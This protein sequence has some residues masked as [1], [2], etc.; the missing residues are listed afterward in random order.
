LKD[1]AL[2]CCQ[3]FLKAMPPFSKKKLFFTEQ[4]KPALARLSPVHLCMFFLF[5]SQFQK[6]I[7]HAGFLFG[8][9]Q[10]ISRENGSL[11][12]SAI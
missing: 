5:P 1:S 7:L 2:A 10:L 8:N 11:P 12:Q 9:E 6:Q 3:E 4:F